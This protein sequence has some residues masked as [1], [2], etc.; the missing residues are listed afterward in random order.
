MC[1]AIEVREQGTGGRNMK[2]E[3]QEGLEQRQQ[4]Q[5]EGQR[6]PRSR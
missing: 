6:R 1:Q 3:V 4:I 5:P 2:R